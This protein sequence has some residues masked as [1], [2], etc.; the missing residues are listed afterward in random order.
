MKEDS[1]LIEFF[2][3]NPLIRIVDY[4]IEKRPFDTTKEEIIQETGISRMS[5]FKYWKKIEGFELVKKTREIGKATLFVLN[6][7]NPIVQ[8]LLILESELIKR[9]MK[10]DSKMKKTVIKSQA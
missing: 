7:E 2:G 9:A 6:D 3:D 1:I 8:K 10:T 5:L 4:L